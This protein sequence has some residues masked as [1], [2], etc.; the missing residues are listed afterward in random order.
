[1]KLYAIYVKIPRIIYD[2][3]IKYILSKQSDFRCK[4]GY[5]QGLYAFTINKK[6]FKEFMGL[7]GSGNQYIVIKENISEEIYNKYH[8]DFSDLE[9]RKCTFTSDSGDVELVVTKNEETSIKFDGEM[10]L[11]EYGPATYATTPYEIFNSDIINAL[12]DLL[13]VSNHISLFGDESEQDHLSFQESYNLSA[14]GR[15]PIY[16]NTNEVNLLLYLYRFFFIG[17]DIEGDGYSEIK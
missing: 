13:Y 14:L 16:T 17:S 15:K 10:L 5:M 11:N 4:K 6:L 2:D 1:M 12:D 8:H 3:K 9:L 7:R